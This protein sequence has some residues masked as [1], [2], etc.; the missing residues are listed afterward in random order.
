MS[1]QV[2]TS[3]LLS[4]QLP[5]IL[6]HASLGTPRSMFWHMEDWRT[7]TRVG[8]FYIQEKLTH[9][10]DDFCPSEDRTASSSL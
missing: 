7:T 5:S 9:S 10:R 2:A 1:P 4:L 8:L 3:E 6:W